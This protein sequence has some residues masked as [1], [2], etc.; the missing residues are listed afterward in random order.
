MDAFVSW[1]H[2]S[3]ERLELL[4]KEQNR[5][6]NAV[7]ELRQWH[8]KADE[9]NRIN[10]QLQQLDAKKKENAAQQE[11]VKKLPKVPHDA[12]HQSCFKRIWGSLPHTLPSSTAKKLGILQEN[13]LQLHVNDV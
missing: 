7:K 8:P 1:L 10:E 6:D 4:Q 13:T 3:D 11:V 2:E 9:M 5:A 12:T